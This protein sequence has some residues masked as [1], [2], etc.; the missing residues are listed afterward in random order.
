V[1]NLV[2]EGSLATASAPPLDSSIK[3]FVDG[4]AEYER[5][6]REN[7]SAFEDI[8]FSPRVLVDVSVID[9]S[10]TILGV[11]VAA[12]IF[13]APTGSHRLLH[14][15]GE[16][17]TAAG[18]ATAGLGYI[19]STASSISLE[20]IATVAGPARWF[21]LYCFRERDV[22]GDLVR[23]ATAAGYTAL[24][25]TVDAPVLGLRLRDLHN[26]FNPTELVRWVNLDPYGVSRLPDDTSGAAISR[27]FVDQ[28][29]A[30]LTIDDLAWLCSFGLPVIV[31]GINRADD[32]AAVCD[33]GVAGVYVSNHGG[34]QLDRTVASLHALPRVV[35]AVAGRVPVIV[36]GGVRDGGDVAAACALGAAVAA[37]GRPVLWA[38]TGG[39]TGVADHLSEL[40]GQL[41]RSMA[42][43]GAPSINELTPDLIMS[44]EPR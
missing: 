28:I 44:K 6:L 29:D 4:G 40:C 21:Q 31:K 13:T 34:R 25:V 1:T 41:R 42:L 35:E 3:D 26:Q 27:Y 2:N 15:Q 18:T 32:A 12:P 30:S 11:G 38:A 9:T 19:A 37:V 33:A 5:T 14:P 39:A 24:V 36:D 16:L 20:E 10:T 23:R 8:R 22:T 43:L 7:R 17:A